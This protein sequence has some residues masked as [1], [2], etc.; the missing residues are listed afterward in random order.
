MKQFPASGLLIFPLALIAAGCSEAPVEVAAVSN[1]MEIVNTH[2]PIM[3]SAVDRTES[4]PAM[5]KDWNG[6]K[7]A[8]CCPPCL[9]EWDELT[10]AEKAEKIAHPPAG[11]GDES[12]GHSESETT[13]APEADSA[14]AE[15]S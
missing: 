15:K 7:V 5:L 2:C 14:P 11:H 1:S 4:D 6:K 3:G 10:D 13:P 9:E 8:F 12:H